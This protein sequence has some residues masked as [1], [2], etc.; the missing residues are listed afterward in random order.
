MFI[1]YYWF[2]QIVI[3]TMASSKMQS[4]EFRKHFQYHV[5]V[6]F[7]SFCTCYFKCIFLQ[8]FIEKE[9]Q[10]RFK[11]ANQNIFPFFGQFSFSLY[12]FL[13]RINQFTFCI[14]RSFAF[15]IFNSRQN[16][17]QCTRKLIVI[18]PLNLINIFMHLNPAINV[19]AHTFINWY[20][21]YYGAGKSIRG[22][23]RKN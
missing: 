10:S 14:E 16:T 17:P 4:E 11:E 12:S 20:L 21:K 3:T 22:N 8:L 23:Y 18:S 13:M 6:Y 19:P 9:N 2:T 15:L 1:G 7:W 5:I